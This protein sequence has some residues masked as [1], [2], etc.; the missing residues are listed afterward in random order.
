MA[1]SATP[2]PMLRALTSVAIALAILVPIGSLAAADR[3]S[4][5]PSEIAQLEIDDAMDKVGLRVD[6][7]SAAEGSEIVVC[8]RRNPDQY[9]IRPSPGSE[10]AHLMSSA[11]RQVMDPRIH[12]ASV[13][14]HGCGSSTVPIFTVSADG[15]IIGDLDRPR[16]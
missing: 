10:R 13:G 2:K 9:R 4:R 6:R 5:G 7:C 11:R 16:R 12:C 8:G 15:V 14:P 3:M 1:K